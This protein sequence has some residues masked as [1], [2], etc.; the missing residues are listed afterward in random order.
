MKI[1]RILDAS[2]VP[3]TGASFTG[4]AKSRRLAAHDAP[5]DVHVYRVE[6]EAGSRTHWHVHSGPQW[7]LVTEGRV[8]VQKWGDAACDLDVGDAVVFDPGEKHWHGATP[9]SR[10]THIAM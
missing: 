1:F 9:G 8:R 5:Y 10:G 2:P 3:T 4:A 6:F 7:L